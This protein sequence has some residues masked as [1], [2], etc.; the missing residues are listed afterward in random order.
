MEYCFFSS[1]SSEEFRYIRRELKMALHVL[2][3]LD[4]GKNSPNADKTNIP[5]IIN[6]YIANIQQQILGIKKT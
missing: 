2:Q 4:Y 6:V 5:P 1:F 3:G